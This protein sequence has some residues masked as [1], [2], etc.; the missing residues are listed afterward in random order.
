[1]RRYSIIA[2]LTVTLFSSAAGFA[3][4]L[5]DHYTAG[6]SKSRSYLNPHFGRNQPPFKLVRSL[7]LAGVTN[8]ISLSVFMNEGGQRLLVGQETPSQVEYHLFNSS[9]GDAEWLPPVVL[10]VNEASFSFQP[11]FFNGIILLGGGTTTSIKAVQASNGAVLWSDSNAG[12]ANGRH[13]IL[14]R[15]AALY[16]GLNGLRSVDPLIGPPATFFSMDVTTAQAPVSV[17]GLQGYLLT[18]SGTLH[19]ISLLDGSSQWSF[20]GLQTDHPNLIASEEFLF[21]N[22]SD[23]PSLGALSTRDGMVLWGKVSP[24]LSTTPAIALAYGQI[25]AFVED[26][27]LCQGVS[28][29]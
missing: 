22:A 24:T 21:I 16:H 27:S 5:G 19:A 18:G 4:Q 26:D 15:N 7:D 9:T 29:M 12:S 10:P 11:S 13:P 3:Q 28:G 20:P 8:A 23:P 14:T 17:F 6:Y 25:Y 1:M 2:V